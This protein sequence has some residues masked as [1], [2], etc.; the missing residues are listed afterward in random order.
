MHLKGDV[1]NAVMRG[2]LDYEIRSDEGPS[3]VIEIADSTDHQHA[4]VDTTYAISS[5]SVSGSFCLLIY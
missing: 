5:N 1:S 4:P 2:S 3:V